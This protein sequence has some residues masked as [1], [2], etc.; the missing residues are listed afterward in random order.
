MITDDKYALGPD[1]TV[2]IKCTLHSDQEQQCLTV[3]GG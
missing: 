1:L 3:Q 2:Q